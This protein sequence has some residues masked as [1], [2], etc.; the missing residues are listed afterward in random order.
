MSGKIQPEEEKPSL[1]P[2]VV[3]G[4][5]SLILPGSGHMLA[6]QFRKGLVL[7]LVFLSA[8]GLW[9]WRVNDAARREIGFANMLKKAIQLQPIVLV[10]LIL[11]VLLYLLIAFDAYKTAAKTKPN[12]L[13]LWVF[14]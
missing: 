11:I 9:I 8:A 3:A 12:S 6:R 5:I 7:L 1:V 13:L 10:I 2:P 4:L 14:V